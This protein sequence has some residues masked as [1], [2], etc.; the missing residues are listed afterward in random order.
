MGFLILGVKQDF[1]VADAPNDIRKLIELLDRRVVLGKKVRKGELEL[2][3]LADVTA[4]T[5]QDDEQYGP[6]GGPVDEYFFIKFFHGSAIF[7]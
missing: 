3:V 6:V 4:D 7:P 2:D 1:E 5:S